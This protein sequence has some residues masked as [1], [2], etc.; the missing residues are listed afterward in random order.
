MLAARVLAGRA[1]LPS[2]ADQQKWEQERIAQSG[3]GVPFTAIY[4]VFQE[5]F[6]T[7][8]KLA[9]EPGEGEPGRR[10]PPF[11]PNWPRIFLQGHQR[12]IKMWKKANQEA[13][14]RLEGSQEILAKL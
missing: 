11:D 14:E 6:E 9:G 4:P 5:Y 3:D 8:R 12:R 2:L 10:L 7:L 1:K 13:K